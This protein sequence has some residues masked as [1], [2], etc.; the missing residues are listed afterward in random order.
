M[1]LCT[2]CI[3]NILV[4]I[5]ALH[6]VCIYMLVR[7]RALHAVCIYNMLEKIM[8]LHTI[9]F[10]NMLVRKRLTRALHTICIYNIV[11]DTDKMSNYAKFAFIK[12]VRKI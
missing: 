1:V 4:R 12:F 5:R 11:Y 7:I 8:E 9:C 10:Y 2:V 6:T 3:Y